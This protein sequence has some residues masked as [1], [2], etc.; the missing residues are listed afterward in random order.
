MGTIVITGARGYIGSILASRLA[1]EG[2]ALR[3][4]SRSALVVPAQAVAKI[5]QVH[6]DL[7][8]DACWRALLDGAEAVIHLSSRTD[9]RAAEVDP[10]GDDNLNVEPVRAL[11]R[12]AERCKTPMSVIFAST[13]TIVGCEHGNPVNELT[14]DRP[15]SV[16][17]RHKLEC[18]TIL[19]NATE[20][21]N[22]RACTLRLS[23]VY[24]YGGSSVNANRGVLNAMLARALRGEPLTLFGEGAYVRDYTHVDDVVDAFC[25]ALNARDVCDGRHYVI[26][27]GR[28]HTLA[29]AY[30]LI[31]EAALDH[32]D[33]RIDIRRIPE[34]LD[35][36]PIERRNFVGNSRLFGRN[37]GWTP[38]FDLRAGVRDYFVRMLA[39]AAVATHQ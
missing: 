7:R 10:K 1:G 31:T 9:L 17:D 30:A 39:R 11:V 13:V 29:E 2:H 3:L 14:P 32:V 27:S 26:S 8:N 5:E 21:G 33:R 19:R 15:C 16:Y 28:G 35:L 12:A 38:H 22:L 36:H 24:G 37:T 20:R 25:R 6:G 34:P 18:E 23:N 4:V